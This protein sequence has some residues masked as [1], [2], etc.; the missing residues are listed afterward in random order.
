MKKT[1]LTLAGG[2]CALFFAL[3]AQAN[4]CAHT[5]SAAYV[6]T[7]CGH[8]P[9][10]GLTKC[11]HADDIKAGITVTPVG[12]APDGWELWD[13]DGHTG[14][15][16]DANAYFG[17]RDGR[18]VYVVYKFV[19][20]KASYITKQ[21][22]ITYNGETKCYDVIIDA[23]VQTYSFIST[24]KALKFENGT[25][26][27]YMADGLLRSSGAGR[28]L[29]ELA[30]ADAA[31]LPIVNSQN[32]TDWFYIDADC[33]AQKYTD[34]MDL[35]AHKK[36]TVT[37]V[38]RNATTRTLTV[39]GA[40]GSE[41]INVLRYATV[42]MNPNGGTFK[43]STDVYTVITS[44]QSNTSVTDVPT[45]D[46][47]VFAGWERAF[48]YDLLSSS[49]VTYTLTL[50]AKWKE[51]PTYIVGDATFNSVEDAVAAAKNNNSAVELPK[52]ESS[53]STIPEAVKDVAVKVEVAA[54]AVVFN[55]AASAVAAGATLNIVE[56]SE[57]VEG[58]AIVY[59]ITLVKGSSNVSELGGSA[60]VTLPVPPALVGKKVAV[61]FVA[62]DGTKTAMENVTVADGRVSFTTTHFST[63]SI[64]EEPIWTGAGTEANP[65]VI[66]NVDGLVEL[67]NRVN[68]GETFAGQYFKLGNDI[69]LADTFWRGIGV[70]SE[71]AV[72]T[73]FQGT[74]DGNG[75]K[76]NGVTFAATDSN[77]YRGFFNQIYKATIK[78]LTIEWNGFEEGTTGT[79]GGAAFVGH[80]RSSTIENCVAEGSF[81]G[82]HNV[83][84]I[85]VR[86]SVD[87][88]ENVYIKGCVNKANLTTSYTKAG[89]IV[90]FSQYITTAYT[91]EDCVN[92][93]TITTDN[94]GNVAGG[95]GGIIGWVGYTGDNTG[96]TEKPVTIKDCVNKATVTGPEGKTGQIAGW[97]STDK[98]IEGTNK[99]LANGVAVAH[100]V[101]GLNFALVTTET[102]EDEEVQ[103]ATYTATLAAN[104]T[105]LV[106]AT[107]A[108]PKIA[109]KGGES[110]TF[111]TTL[112]TIDA[113]GITPAS[114]DGAIL[115][116][117][118]EDAKVT[119]TAAIAKVGEV[120]Y[121]DF[122]TALEAAKNAED[123]TVTVLGD[124]NWGDGFAVPE[125]VTIKTGADVT[126][127]A[128][129]GYEWSEEDALVDFE[130]SGSIA[131]AIVNMNKAEI[132][133][134]KW[135]TIYS[136]ATIRAQKSMVVKLYSGQTLLG[137]TELVDK[138]NVLKCGESKSVTWHFFLDGEDPDWW[139][140]TWEAKPLLANVVP[141]KVELWCDG[142]K[143]SK[144]TV[145]MRNSND[146][147]G[148]DTEIYNWGDLEN[149]MVA[150][151]DVAGENGKTEPKYYDT[152]QE[153]IDAATAGETVTLLG[154]TKF[155]A[156]DDKPATQAWVKEGKDVIVDLNN[157]TVDGAF[158]INGTATIK[159]GSIVN[160]DF[161]SGIETKGTLTLQDVTV[162]SN[163][164]GVRVS[165]GTTTIE[166]GTY[167]STVA[168]GSSC[169]AVNASGNETVLN[170]QGGTFYGAGYANLGG[171]GNCVMDQGCQSVTISGGTFLGANGV[172]GPLCVASNTIISGGKFEDTT[173]SFRY[174]TKLDKGYIA[175]KNDDGLYEVEKFTNWLQVA[176]TTWYD[177]EA[178]QTAYTLSSAEQLAGLAK[179]VNAGTSFA[180][181][182]ITLGANIDLSG[183]SYGEGVNGIAW[184]PIGTS[185][186]PFLGNFDGASKKVSNL[187]VDT[188]AD[189][190]G[191]FG[192]V[193]NNPEKRSSITNLT[194]ENVDIGRSADKSYVGALVGN[195]FC[196]DFEEC[197]V[198]GTFYV[199]GQRYV[200]G[201]VGH[202]YIKATNC[203]VKTSEKVFQN[204]LRAWYQVGGIIG[205]G[206]EAN[207]NNCKV[208]NI[209]LF[210]RVGGWVGGMVGQCTE[211]TLRIE[212]STLKD[213]DF[214]AL[215]GNNED[216]GHE[217]GLFA[218]NVGTAYVINNTVEN[219]TLALHDYSASK[220]ETTGLK[221]F[222]KNITTLVGIGAYN[223]QEVVAGAGVVLDE[224]KK[225]VV[226]A[227]SCEYC[228]DSLVAEGSI[229][230]D[231]GDGTCKVFAIVAK[232]GDTPYATI[233]AAIDAA[234]ETANT[235]VVVGDVTES[236]IT[237]ATDDKVVI[238]LDGNTVY[239][240]FMVHGN[241]T[242]KNGT[243]DST[244]TGKSGIETN[245][246]ADRTFSPILVTENLTILSGRH[247]LRVDGGT[248][249]I[250]SGSYTAA[251]AA[252]N[253][254][255]NISDGGKVTIDGG[256]FVGNSQSGTGAVAMRGETSELTINDGTFTGGS[257]GS[258]TVWEGTT[259]VNGG[260][261]ET[262]YADQPV[263]IVGGV[264]DAVNKL[265]AGSNITGGTFKTDPSQYLSE[266]Y[267]GVKQD[268]GTYK[269]EKVTNWIQ[270]AD[271]S[272][273]NDTDMEFALTTAKQLAGLAKLVNEGKDFADKTVTLDADI[274]L[275]QYAWTPIGTAS[276]TPFSGIFNGSEKTI[277]NVKI[278]STLAG[279]GLF[280]R[281]VKATVSDMVVNS[282]TVKSTQ[283]YTGVVV[284]YAKGSTIDNCDVTGVVNVT[285]TYRVAV[286]LGESVGVNTDAGGPH[287]VISNC[288]V[289]GTVS[290]LGGWDVG[291]VVGRAICTDIS[292]CTLTGTD[293]AA[294]ITVSEEIYSGAQY[295][296]GI[297]GHD[298]EGV[299]IKNCSV[300]NVKLSATNFV[301]GISAISQ[302]STISKCSAQDV[303][304]TV[305]EGKTGVGSIAGANNGTSKLYNNT[306]DSDVAQLALYTTGSA[307]NNSAFVGTRVV[308][309]E[310]NKVKSG[311]FTVFDETKASTVLAPRA[312]ATDNGD[313][314]WI[315]QMA[316]AEVTINGETSR[317]ASLQAAINAAVKAKG[318]TIKLLADCTEEVIVS[319]VAVTPAKTRSAQPAI[320]LDL[321]G[322]T[323][324]KI[325]V[326]ENASLS[327]VGTGTVTTLAAEVGT[328]VTKEEGVI[329][330][331]MPE[332]TSWSEPSE[333]GEDSIL[334]RNECAVTITTF[335]AGTFSGHESGRVVPAGTILTLT[336]TAN[337]GHVFAGWN[338]V[339]ETIDAQATT[340]MTIEVI[341]TEA[342]TITAHFLP[343]TLYSSALTEKV[344]A[345]YTTE[346]A[347]GSAN[348]AVVDGETKTVTLG[349]Q[350]QKT[351]SLEAGEKNWT[352]LIPVNDTTIEN[353]G[354]IKVS[355]PVPTDEN[356]AF[357]KFVPKND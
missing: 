355:L 287:N 230:V 34:R 55:A 269:I 76:I 170:I 133:G 326:E 214:Y 257:E 92:E 234:T 70:Y 58:A 35:S 79:Y 294:T 274:D 161:V 307:A 59:E 89:G 77:K 50:T 240:D 184:T 33:S 353:D 219:C 202:G 310:T 137:T 305:A 328:T 106:T 282:A 138:E 182:T 296:G 69:S 154:D 255:V 160:N 158:F 23:S 163:R 191:F 109:L 245:N 4:T 91:I 17:E 22:D 94:A 129:I 29:Y 236:G 314:T 290:V 36:D 247:A 249:N 216:T 52:S 65:Y 67:A 204:N 217:T 225:K 131:Q 194:L 356:K 267:V 64:E 339:G 81:T 82:T 337:E 19:S 83:A 238:D 117:K 3:V 21:V 315:V 311:T 15:Q 343:K 203:S 278:N 260:A 6:C 235:I 149:V 351:T 306:T 199:N 178:P 211:G 180:D 243:I 354:T 280:G 352:P 167:Q 153:A 262:V 207:L 143:V 289:S 304:L 232:I 47:Y 134:G 205:Q 288:D 12:T 270:V 256:T 41:V 226:T 316:V 54:G 72:G 166:S 340:A 308:F 113:T 350:L 176:N 108:K 299:T 175:V 120:A 118:T 186:K 125:G 2:A 39:T 53:S 228:A 85:V 318:G 144:S 13:P 181:A 254:A 57:E 75:K 320:S 250:K 215:D 286:V 115:G 164:H 200:G 244:S 74:F 107:G 42:R 146:N 123:K 198:T 61:F 322:F 172:E 174:T 346:V 229:K 338:V 264:F 62:E 162:T 342:T 241:A 140:T 80:A 151:I 196:V 188:G 302:S 165:G 16:T 93:G 49:S 209:H 319:N 14:S 330:T 332:G 258:L 237:V 324:A 292:S 122:N 185:A 37:I 295:A 101:G 189:Y 218:G 208:E 9:F 283:N 145:S 111:D 220:D 110:I 68:A 341:I 71:T 293:S 25:E 56:S 325:T 116:P 317:Y 104:N 259:T 103:V 201:M 327:L 284:G 195:A 246:E 8:A 171:T 297:L 48:T 173:E 276:S 273:Y 336:A 344:V 152:L 345:D 114:A 46:G 10:D 323:V 271:T 261:F 348:I 179:L 128:P 333:D 212:N 239:G 335:G 266:G 40:D 349:I 26:I 155:A 88:S 105:Y 60:V 303:T 96:L 272:W 275:A 78:N 150:K 177:A 1:L 169:H 192:K 86:F 156:E 263:T 132:A 159:N 206:P 126:V 222:I 329:V 102:I 213:V 45:K 210:A 127:K 300:R 148:A 231:N 277:S 119:Y 18:R 11:N 124:V 221:P 63:Y 279:T 168:K 157:C 141:D 7:T 66:G 309:D 31:K 285:G 357:F 147:L 43:N 99:G 233:Q 100:N 224:S 268:D 28:Y 281:I 24:P 190:Q 265:P 84:G 242:I 187:K 252:S 331:N 183:A 112:T 87:G 227:E 44:M 312:F 98:Y 193:N 27:V 139:K 30:T 223:S 301:G 20:A 251:D 51:P 73:A 248:V 334:T 291:G 95:F 321:N 5:Y 121:G 197:H 130:P 97:I 32:N 136:E 313:G 38:N 142:K 298:N 347:L 90:A 135:Q 253:H